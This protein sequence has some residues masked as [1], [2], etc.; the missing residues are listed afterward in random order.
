MWI[1]IV[2]KW[3]FIFFAHRKKWQN[4]NS[5]LKCLLQIYLGMMK[6]YHQM[7]KRSELCNHAYS[8]IKSICYMLSCMHLNWEA[9][10]QSLFRIL[11]QSWVEFWLFLAWRKRR[12][13]C[14]TT[15]RT[16]WGWWRYRSSRCWWNSPWRRRGRRNKNWCHYSIL[17]ILSGLWVVFCKDAKFL[18]H[19]TQ[20]IWPSFV[21]RWNGRRWGFRWRRKSQAE[22]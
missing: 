8:L 9:D 1:G 5:S 21:R 6:S 11:L 19:W 13:T 17:S 10:N 18:E 3:V 2:F 7:K 16:S 4:P 22:A 14:R 15:R 20:T 12:K